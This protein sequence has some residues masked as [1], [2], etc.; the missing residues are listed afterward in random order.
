MSVTLREF[1]SERDA[2]A[3][4]ASEVARGYWDHIPEPPPRFDPLRVAIVAIG[5]AILVLFLCMAVAMWWVRR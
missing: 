4:I 3:G 2:A 5:V 1:Q